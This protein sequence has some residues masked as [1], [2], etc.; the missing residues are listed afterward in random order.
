MILVDQKSWHFRFMKF[1]GGYNFEA[2]RSLCGYFWTFVFTCL[3]AA[4]SIALI[5]FGLSLIPMLL[6]SWLANHS[7]SARVVVLCILGSISVVLVFSGFVLAIKATRDALSDKVAEHPTSTVGLVIGTVLGFK[8]K[9]CPRILYVV[10][11][12]E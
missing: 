8:Q 4:G 11:K 7:T 2:P 9:V 10:N 6:W 5:S 1:W 3:R 12:A